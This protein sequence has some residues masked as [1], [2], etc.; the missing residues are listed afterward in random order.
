MNIT[1]TTKLTHKLDKW[2]KIDKTEIFTQ[3]TLGFS[4]STLNL[5]L[6]LPVSLALAYGCA[7]VSAAPLL[8]ADLNS[9][10][11]FAS[12][13][14]TA[15]GGSTVHGSFLSGAGATLGAGSVVTGNLLAVEGATVGVG[16][17]VGGNLLAGAG[18]T[19][20]ANSTVAGSFHAGAAAT[21]GANSSVGGN[22][23]AGAAATLGANSRVSGNVIAGAAVTGGV[24]AQIIGTTK[25]STTPS[26]LGIPNTAS[27][28]V[29]AAQV[30]DT[31]TSLRSL[32]SGS[33]LAATMGGLTSLTA[34]IYSATALTTAAGTVLSLD[35]QNLAN[36]LWVFN[37]DTYLVTGASTKI[38][39]I[40]AGLGSSVI[41]NTGGYTS[42]GADTSFLG[43]LIAG[44]YVSM[45]ANTK[46]TGANT[47]CGGIFSASSYVVMGAEAQV[48]SAGCSGAN[49]AYWAEGSNTLLAQQASAV[50]A[51][52]EPGEL[53][54]LLSGL[55]LMGAVA[56]RRKRW[57]GGGPKISRLRHA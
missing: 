17:T 10:S 25:A 1:R 13:Y 34:G 55:A 5:K 3:T 16:A 36:Q 33:T 49:T 43:T 48:G 46:V 28:N 7:A 29:Q 20:G 4:M 37:I 44:T 35:G 6:A 8:G 21:L 23:H 39:L 42:L 22:V 45:G 12:G 32:V 56:N 24:G 26:F 2:R 9:Q 18:A 19:L 52:S 57:V 30:A 14:V 38:N 54:M 41:W 40:N 31:Q 27:A 11:V 15:G 50:S 53:W 47:S 51:V